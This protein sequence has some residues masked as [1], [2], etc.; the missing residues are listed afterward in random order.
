MR[1]R[2]PLDNTYFEANTE[3]M[4]MLTLKIREGS[5][6]NRDR[7]CGALKHHFDD[8]ESLL[9]R[10]REIR[11]ID[12]PKEIL[13]EISQFLQ[14]KDN[15]ILDDGYTCLLDRLTQIYTQ[16]LEHQDDQVFA[17]TAANYAGVIQVV[18]Q[19]H[20]AYDYS[21]VIGQLLHYMNQLYKNR[22]KS[23]LRIFK[24]L[25]SMPDSIQGIQVLKERHLNE[26]QQWIEEG[27]D[28]LFEL[29]DDQIQLFSEKIAE[30]ARAEEGV[31]H[32]LKE[33]DVDLDHQV[34]PITW[35]KDKAELKAL[36]EQR[37]LLIDDLENKQKL[38]D[39]LEQNMQ[40]F[41]E[42]LLTTRRAYLIHSV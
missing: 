22:E 16:G 41:E 10:K 4:G 14:S 31:E 1:P 24:Y 42:I 23:W 5:L 38:V 30:L 27:V 13:I 3:S 18:S 9:T 15:Q 40:E 34:L 21:E 26:I 7:A 37:D 17:D 12:Q 36:I 25:L 19:T 29:R 2:N 28:N 6:H 32:K 11:D 20:F 33:M 8:L 35:L 39:L